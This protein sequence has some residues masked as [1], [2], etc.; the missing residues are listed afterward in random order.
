VSF[1]ADIGHIENANKVGNLPLEQKDHSEE[2]E[3]NSSEDDTR[4]SRLQKKNK[5]QGPS[6]DNVIGSGKDAGVRNR[7]NGVMEKTVAGACVSLRAK[8]G[9]GLRGGGVKGRR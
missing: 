2:K 5:G 6:G 9:R 3:Q 4:N 7:E 8:K 1:W